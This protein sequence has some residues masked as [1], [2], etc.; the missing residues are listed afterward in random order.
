MARSPHRWGFA[1]AQS[2]RLVDGEGTAKERLLLQAGIDEAPAS[3]TGRERTLLALGIVASATT[4]ASSAP[5]AAEVGRGL[6]AAHAKWLIFGVAGAAAAVSGIE[7]ATSPVTV[8]LV[9][10]SV[11]TSYRR[12][13]TQ[14]LPIAANASAAPRAPSPNP[15]S[16]AI[17]PRAA[18]NDARAAVDSPNQP[19]IAVPAPERDAEL[20]H[21]SE[22]QAAPSG[23]VA[24]V[25][26]LD[27]ARTALRAG[28]ARE[29]MTLLD[30]FDRTYPGSTL[31]PEATVLRVS[32]LLTLG[33]RAQA[34]KLVQS[35][36]RLGGRDAYGQRLVA[37]VGL[38]EAA[39]EDSEG[40]RD[41]SE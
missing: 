26:A 39:C 17:S 5:A 20:R 22:A 7:M 10:P 37:L 35:Y 4:L 31:A 41:R 6:V 30:S 25:A 11:A 33:R 29:S 32:A 9:A 8:P 40:R 38:D 23:L 13:S 21:S 2:R 34:T 24:Q 36:C 14:P 12:P 16:P 18:R 1:S 15:S 28:R 27:R 19:A 3:R